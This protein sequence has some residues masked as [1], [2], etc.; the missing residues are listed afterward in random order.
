MEIRE[1]RAFAAAA[2]D[3]SGHW[4]GRGGPRRP[5]RGRA[6]E[7]PVGLL[8]GALTAVTAAFLETRV[9]IGHAFSAAQ[10]TALRVGELDVA[11][12]RMA[13]RLS[14]HPALSMAI[15]AGSI[16]MTLSGFQ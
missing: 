3:G 8:P 14:C 7:L 4:P 11:L 5:A 15:T 13:A 6:L 16:H 10:L 1:L 12:A 2:E 9:E